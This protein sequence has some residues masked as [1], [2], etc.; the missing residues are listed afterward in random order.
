MLQYRPARFAGSALMLV[1]VVWKEA[2]TERISY[3]R[4][5]WHRVA[6]PVDSRTSLWATCATIG[7]R[8]ASAS[9][10]IM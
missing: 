3:K 9:V 2:G 5:E 8:L 4:V 7:V 6:P 10:M 1:V